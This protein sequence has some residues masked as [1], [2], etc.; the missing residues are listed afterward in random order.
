MTG[1]RPAEQPVLG[2]GRGFLSTNLPGKDGLGIPLTSQ[3]CRAAAQPQEQQQLQAR[4]AAAPLSP[5]AHAGPAT[6]L[7]PRP[8]LRLQTSARAAGEERSRFPRC[9]FFSPPPSC[10]PPLLSPTPHPPARTEPE[11]RP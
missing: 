11:L 7:L 9:L 8:E 3:R 6:P 1:V 10:F 2:A 4:G 5:S